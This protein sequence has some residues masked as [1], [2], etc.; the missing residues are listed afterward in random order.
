MFYFCSAKV[1]PK[2]IISKIAT[3]NFDLLFT[4]RKSAA[5]ASPAT[6]K[7]RPMIGQPLIR[8]SLCLSKRGSARTCLSPERL[9]IPKNITT[10][11]PV[12]IQ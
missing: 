11:A 7:R 9:N 10:F 3:I 1:S 12:Y 8:R 2:K 5:S 6:G 4:A